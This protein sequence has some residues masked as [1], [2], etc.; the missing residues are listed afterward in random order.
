MSETTLRKELDN[1]KYVDLAERRILKNNTISTTKLHN[2]LS[3]AM[4]IYNE[5]KMSTS[6]KLEDKSIKKL[7]QMRVR[8]VYEAREAEIKNFLNDAKILIYIKEIGEDREAF[9]L[10]VH[11]LEALVAYHSFCA[12]KRE[13]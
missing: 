12:K 3:L 13:E 2:I 5:E 6:K 11:Y 8:I 10:F 1:G 4:D 7:L 9:V